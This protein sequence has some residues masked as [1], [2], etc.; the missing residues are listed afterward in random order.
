MLGALALLALVVTS[1][2]MLHLLSRGDGWRR[3]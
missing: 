1:G 2:G 3:P